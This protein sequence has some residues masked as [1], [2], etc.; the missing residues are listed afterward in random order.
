[1]AGSHKATIG[2]IN[3]AE[4]IKSTHAKI[5]VAIILTC[6]A[7]SKIVVVKPSTKAAK[8][9]KNDIASKAFVTTVQEAKATK[10]AK[11]TPRGRRTLTSMKTSQMFRKRQIL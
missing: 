10:E 3:I 11:K 2:G 6:A 8:A 5:V 9:K 7:N 4:H 1:M